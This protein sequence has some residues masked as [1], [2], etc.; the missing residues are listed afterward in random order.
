MNTIDGWMDIQY[1]WMDGWMYHGQYKWM[2]ALM[3]EHYRWMYGWMYSKD[4][5]MH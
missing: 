5:W 3:N 2:D 4:G 1:R